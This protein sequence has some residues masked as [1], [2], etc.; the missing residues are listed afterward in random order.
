M[1]RKSRKQIAVEEPIIESVSSEVFSTAIYARLSVENSGKSEKV[2]VI[3]NQIEICKSYIAE[4]PY[5]NLIDTYV[6]N[7]RT[8]TVFDRPEF[9]RL[10]NDIRTGRIKC[11]V[12]RD[13][14]RFGRDYIEA[15]TYLERVFPQIGLRFIAI[16]ENYDNFDTDGSGESLIIPLQNMINTLYSKDISRKVS[17]ALKAQMESGEFKKRNLPYG[18]RWDEE[19]SNMVFDEET[20]PI[21]RKIFQWKIEGLSLPAIADRLDAMN[22]PNPEFQKYQVGVRTGNATAK[23][24]WNKSSL[25]TILDN[26][27]YVGDTVLGRTLNAIYKGVKNQHI[28]REEWIVFPNTHEA[29]I[30]REDFQKVR[31]M[32]NAAARTRVEKMERTEEIRATLINLFEDKIVCA[33]CGRKLYF[34]RKR[35]DKRKDG[36]WYAFY[37]CSSSVKRGNLCTPHY[38][39]QDKLE[40]DVLAAIQLQVKAALNYDKLLAKLR[41]SEGERSI[42]DQQNALIT[43]LNLKLSGISKKRSLIY[44][45]SRFRHLGDKKASMTKGKTPVV[46]SCLAG[47]NSFSGF[48]LIVAC[49][50][51]EI[52][53]VVQLGVAFVNEFGVVG[54]QA[55][56]G[57]TENLI[58]HRH[59]DKAAVN[60]FAEH[61]PGAYTGKLIRVSDKNDPCSTFDA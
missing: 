52:L 57:L 53:A 54:D 58:Q 20:A 49:H 19:H 21:V 39:R 56:L 60:Q 31:E 43:S 13:L 50:E 41:N 44:P 28:D 51:N 26:P 47:N 27:H 59:G 1:A 2:D 10:M 5:L 17:T 33:D 14:S 34:H 6:D 7:G 38:T 12:V 29:I 8:G 35:V 32:R 18:Y 36:A 16:K 42:R 46:H 4:R 61:I 3:A 24:I 22:A 37:E 9:N 40:A 23:K 48:R 30:S 15:G 45:Q 25:T 55:V 11:L